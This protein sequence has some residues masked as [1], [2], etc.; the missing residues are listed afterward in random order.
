MSVASQ[1][2]RLSMLVLVQGTG[3]NQVEAR[4]ESLGDPTVLLRC[5]LLRNP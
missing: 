3:K 5:F 2:R 4:Q 1:K